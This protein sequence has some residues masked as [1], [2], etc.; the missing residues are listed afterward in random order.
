MITCNPIFLLFSTYPSNIPPANFMFCFSSVAP[1]SPVS[2]AHT[3]MGHGNLPVTSS[4]KGMTL[5][6]SLIV[7]GEE[8]LCEDRGLESIY[9]ICVRILCSW[10]HICCE[11]MD[12]IA[13]PCPEKSISPLSFPPAHTRVT[14]FTSLSIRHLCKSW[15]SHGTLSL[16][17]TVDSQQHHLASFLAG[18]LAHV[19]FTALTYTMGL[20]MHRFP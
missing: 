3:Y 6:S 9:P 13:L 1:L 5:P 15:L 2:P 16:P 18:S 14:I 7:Y 4:S 20:W 8:L 11:L 19:C 12:V 17:S 10:T